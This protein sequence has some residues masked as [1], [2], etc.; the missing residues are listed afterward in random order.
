M[1]IEA[2]QPVEAGQGRDPPAF[3]VGLRQAV[4]LLV[5]EHLHPVLQVAEAAVGVAK[6]VTSRVRDVPGCGQGIEGVEGA[7]AS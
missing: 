7:K 1:R 5:G 4:G 3:G 2:A 6:L